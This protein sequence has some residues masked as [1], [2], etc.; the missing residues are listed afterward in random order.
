MWQKCSKYIKLESTSVLPV[1]TKQIEP[2]SQANV[3]SHTDVDDV[4][5]SKVRAEI[6]DSA[7]SVQGVSV[8]CK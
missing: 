2:T 8:G 1:N 3:D 6:E 5:G 4:H 7:E